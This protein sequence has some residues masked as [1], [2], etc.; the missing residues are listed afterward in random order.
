MFVIQRNRV[1]LCRSGHFIV[2]VLSF[3]QILHPV[4]Q[5]WMESSGSN[6]IASLSLSILF[7]FFLKYIYIIMQFV[8]KQRQL[9]YNYSKEASNN[10][11][12]KSS[13]GGLE[14]Q[15][16]RVLKT[17]NEEYVIDDTY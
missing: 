11:K 1:F 13:G 16:S 15:V 6:A 5:Y 8:Y 4:P 3:H 17:S 10:N 14:L 7:D 9:I 12:N 2:I